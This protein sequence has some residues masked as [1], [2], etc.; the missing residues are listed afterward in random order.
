LVHL[1][2]DVLIAQY[3]RHHD[4]YYKEGN[5]ANFTVGDNKVIMDLHTPIMVAID[6]I[7]TM[8]N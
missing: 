5:K 2:D 6:K 3:G 1:H 8:D 7:R 4:Y